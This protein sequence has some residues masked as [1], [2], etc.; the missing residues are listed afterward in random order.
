MKIKTKL[1]VFLILITI[2]PLFIVSQIYIRISEKSFIQQEFEHFTTAAELKKQDLDIWIRHMRQDFTAAAE[3]IG[4]KLKEYE[5]HQNEEE[6]DPE[7]EKEEEEIEELLKWLVEHHPIFSDFIVLEGDTG[8]AHLSSNPQELKRIYNSEPFF[9]EGKKGVYLQGIFF[10]PSLGT[11][12]MWISEPFYEEETNQNWVIAARINME[13]LFTIM[14]NRSGLGNTG[15]T[16]LVDTYKQV[17]GYSRFLLTQKFIRVN[18]EGVNDCLLGNNGQ[19]D[20]ADYRGEQVIGVYR[21]LDDLNICLLAE[22]DK[23]EVFAAHNQLK[24]AIYLAMLGLILLLYAFSLKFTKGF[25]KPIL[26]LT[27]IAK[28]I[29]AGNLKRRVPKKMIQKDD[30][31]AFL[32]GAFDRMSNKL[33][34]ALINTQNI[35]STMPSALFILNEKAEILRVNKKA[36]EIL[37]I[38]EKKLIGK[39]F[40]NY[41]TVASSHKDFGKKDLKLSTIIKELP[42]KLDKGNQKKVP[43]SLSGVPMKKEE[44]GKTEK[45]FIIT[46]ADLREQKRYAHSR[47]KEI[48]PIL[49]RI[50][51]GDFETKLETPKSSDEFADLI[52]AIDLMADNL[53]QLIHENRGKT[54]ELVKSQ[55]V[56]L[57]A[58]AE[59]DREKAKAEALLSHIGE[60][61][62]AISTSGEIIFL[63]LKAESSFGKKSKTVIG[64]DYFKHFRFEG[65]DGSPM[66]LDTYPIKDCVKKKKPVHTVCY[67][68]HK[69]GKRIPFSTTVAPI[70][71]KG[72]LLGIV[73]TFRDITEEVAIDKSKSEFV[74]LASHQMR[75]PMTGIKW[76]IQAAML[77]GNLNEKQVDFLQDALSSNDRMIRL[78]DDLL[79]VSRIDSGSIA[80]EPQEGNLSE[81]VKSL[82]HEYEATAKGKDQQVIFEKPDKNITFSFDPLL[83]SE[84]VSNLVSNALH[85]S[86]KGKVVRVVLKDSRNK[87]Y[88]RVEDEGIGISAKD[89]KKLFTKFYR[90]SEASQY[91]TTGSGLGLYIVKEILKVTGGTIKLKSKPGKG[92]V[93]TV[94]LPKNPPRKQQG[95]SLI[96]KSPSKE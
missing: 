66:N 52:V 33:A 48:T 20:Y 2:I 91:S 60:A 41:F 36:E 43:V 30:E 35:V 88:I 40:F 9:T 49:N 15:E 80:F 72:K 12:A 34:N 75:T 53:R 78:V 89:Q 14:N 70:L 6:E 22:V 1:N 92:T 85:Y 82:T 79:N 5:L 47:V 37:K 56:L 54:D 25:M 13:D 26:K 3:Q 63:N 61:V 4:D 76:M 94:T 90:T 96:Q 18:S 7:H 62:I 71:I 46:A 38:S 68:I 64:K 81:L 28:D 65:K 77:Q 23:T 44:K 86:K 42:G 73:G 24:L 45:R 19:G 57:K 83:T 27:D 55:K 10:S 51:L 8:S 39:D 17:I 69:N 32:A 93:F 59:T 16:Y 50:S 87:V 58:K 11:S 21:W 84:I 95:K 29:S 74:S 67:F 31:I